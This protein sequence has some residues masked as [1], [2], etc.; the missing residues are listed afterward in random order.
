MSDL[1]DAGGEVLGMFIGIPMAILLVCCMPFMLVDSCNNHFH[2]KPTPSENVR[3]SNKKFH[4]KKTSEETLSFRAGQQV[5]Q[6][7]KDFV[8]GLWKKKE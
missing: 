2:P 1:G 4:P 5:K 6:S 7:S 3:I 8:R